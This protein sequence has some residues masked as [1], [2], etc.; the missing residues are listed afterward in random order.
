MELEINN[1]KTNYMVWEDKEFRT[2][3]YFSIET[4]HKS[5]FKVEEVELFM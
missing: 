2:G 3:N 5:I 4:S 1:T